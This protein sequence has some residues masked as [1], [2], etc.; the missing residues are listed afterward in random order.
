MKHLKTFLLILLLIPC[1]FVFNACSFLEDEQVYVT[2]IVQTEEVG[3]YATYT[4]YYSNGET[5]LFTVKN[6]KDGQD[7]NSPEIRDI[8]N[9]YVAQYG[10]ISYQDFLNKYLS[11]NENLSNKENTIQDATNIAMK[12]AVT[13]WC[14]HKTSD[15]GGTNKD[16]TIACGAG[17]IYKVE[18]T[19]S[20]IVTNYHVIYYKDS[21]ASNK[22]ASKIHIFQYGTEDKYYNKTVDDGNGNYKQVYDAQGYPE[23]VYGYGAIEA[24]YV[25]GEMTYDLAV[26][27]V[28]TAELRKYFENFSAVEVADGYELA[29]TAIAIGNPEMMGFSVTSGIISV[30][31]EELKMK[32]PDETT[33]CEFRVMRIDTA[34]NGGNSGG[35]LFNISGEWIGIVN[36]KA[37][38]SD[39]DN[40][41]YAIPYENVV[42]IVENILYYYNGTIPCGAKKLVLGITYFGE[43]SHAIYDPNTNRTTI[44]DD[45]EIKTVTEGSMAKSI[46]LEVGDIIKALSINGVEYQITR[47]YILPD[48]LLTV[49]AGDKIMFTIKRGTDTIQRGLTTT[50]GIPENY[51]QDV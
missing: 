3:D 42:A 11:I 13:I 25:G 37:V 47:S 15:V 1:A 35:G 19:Y 21:N 28:P 18:E 20:Y 6:G 23:V 22:L 27:K 16:L 4:I 9:E 44:Y 39:I 40:I 46:G 17:V 51:L 5:A 33:N 45:L 24:T 30:V 14:E 41:A 48:L 10:N 29:E 38:S 26:L 43:N 49:R 8:Y 34:V 50:E 7:G 36:A 12:S 31:S 2:D 32:G